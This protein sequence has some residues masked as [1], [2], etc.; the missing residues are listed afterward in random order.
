V[1]E[2]LKLTF[3]AE[4]ATVMVVDFAPAELGVKDKLPVVQVPPGVKTAFAVQVPKPSTNS[5]S[6]EEN[7]V[8]PKVMDP[9]FAVKLTVPQEPV[10]LMPWVA[11]QESEVGLTVK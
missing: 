5:A 7:G 3:A 10:V 9:P 8:A 1:P 4:L 2:A 6:E 11:E